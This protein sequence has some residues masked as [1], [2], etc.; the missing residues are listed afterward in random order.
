[1]A[2]KM[3]EVVSVNELLTSGPV[4]YEVVEMYKVDGSNEELFKPRF[5]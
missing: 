4:S 1:M 3:A 5:R 2:T